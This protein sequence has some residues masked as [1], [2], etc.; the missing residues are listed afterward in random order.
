M[1]IPIKQY[2]FIPNTLAQSAQV[3]A[4]LNT[5]Y[6]WANQGLDH[7][8]VNP[9]V[10]FYASD[11]TSISSA[12]GTF[13]GGVGATNGFT[14]LAPGSGVTPLSIVGVSGQTADIFDIFNLA[15]GTKVFSIDGSGEGQFTAMA[16]GDIPLTLNGAASPS[17]DLFDIKYNSGATK[18]FWVDKIGN[19]ASVTAL[20]GDGGTVWQNAAI[21]LALGARGTALNSPIARWGVTGGG[22][23]VG[24]LNGG[25]SSVIAGVTGSLFSFSEVGVATLATM[26]L[27]GNLG[28]AGALGVAS[29]AVA[30]SSGV[31]YGGTVTLTATAGSQSLPANPAGFIV[32]NVNNTTQKIPYYNA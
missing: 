9:A 12:S 24:A 30:V 18:A 32:V 16:N 8:N 29:A 11:I 6:G 22:T 20:F 10:G 21:G 7:S 14:F 28:L 17:V 25:T 2:T 27:S 4:D 15:A 1:T 19:V 3:N 5:L 26:D 23:Q 31:S 13:G